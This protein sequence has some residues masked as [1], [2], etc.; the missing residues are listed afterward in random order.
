MVTYHICDKSCC[1]LLQNEN[2]QLSVP[3]KPAAVTTKGK[4]IF[5]L[6]VSIKSDRTKQPQSNYIISLQSVFRDEEPEGTNNNGT[7][8]VSQVICF[9]APLHVLLN[10][11]LYHSTIKI[12]A[13]ET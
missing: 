13:Q 6:L 9:V 10:K 11:L 1:S 4:Y 7:E 8:D 12:T 3:A 2:Y 5:F